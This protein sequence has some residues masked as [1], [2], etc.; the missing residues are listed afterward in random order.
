MPKL[1]LVGITPDHRGLV[2][3]EHARS[4]RGD[5]VLEIDDRLLEAIEKAQ[6]LRTRDEGHGLESAALP[7]KRIAVN[8]DAATVARLSPREIQQ[9]LRAGES[10]TAM[11]RSSGTD[12][13]WIRRFAAP[14]L[15]EQ[16][17]VIEQARTLTLTK[18]GVGPSGATL[19][20]SVA[21]N[22]I[23]RGVPLTLPDLDAGW[24]AYQRPEGGWHVTFTFPLRGRRQTAEWELDVAAGDLTARNKL[25]SELGWREP[26]KRLPQPAP[27][28]S[29]PAPKRP[30]RGATAAV[31]GA[32]SAPDQG[33]ATEGA[34]GPDE[35][36]GLETAA[37]EA[38]SPSGV[39]SD[40]TTGAESATLNEH[41]MTGGPGS[42]LTGDATTGGPA[43]VLTGDSTTG[44]SSGGA[45]SRA[46]TGA[47]SGAATD[48]AM[49]GAA[50]GA[51][52]GPA[53]AGAAKTAAGDTESAQSLPLGDPEPEALPSS[54]GLVRKAPA[55]ARKPAARK[56]P[57]SKTPT[58]KPAAP[59]A[60]RAAA[61]VTETAAQSV[62]PVPSADPDTGPSRRAGS[63]P[64]T[65]LDVV[66]VLDDFPL[67]DEHD[68]PD[69]VIVLPP[70]PED[71]AGDWRQASGS[72]EPEEQDD[73]P[74]G[75]ISL[76]ARPQ[77]APVGPPPAPPGGP[78]AP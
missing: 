65:D 47:E 77:P 69:T 22:V 19:G 3:S 35:A 27:A 45:V 39:A 10:I 72:T 7:S 76:R 68:R 70:S 74:T 49:A 25:A 62:A 38:P 55:P 15:A 67:L 17:K 61:A 1:H 31:P 8:G 41:V 20:P 75:P 60:K 59:A 11:A 46:E 23:D 53:R 24:G 36:S 6:R 30:A 29:A 43:G 58:R 12:E 48:N 9:R 16:A 64:P 57:A 28:R 78:P 50:P 40:V 63:M 18:R 4:K 37:V 2:L 14:V 54:G 56:A 13:A 33:S 71:E 44:T 51:V 52:A 34:A 66:D 21:A 42:V 26:G 5:M 32:P 73:G